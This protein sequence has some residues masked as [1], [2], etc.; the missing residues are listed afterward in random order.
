MVGGCHGVLLLSAKRSVSLV[1]WRTT[2]E[3]RIDENHGETTTSENTRPRT[4]CSVMAQGRR[5]DGHTG[6]CAKPVEKVATASEGEVE[7][8]TAEREIPTVMADFGQSNL[9]L[10]CC[11]VLF[12]VCGCVWLCV[13]L[14]VVVCCCVLLVW[15]LPIRRRTPPPDRPKLAFF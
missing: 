14:C 3:R 12:V 15:T 8:R 6:R 2:H 4:R 13:L 11:C 1:F 10:L 5:G 7:E 9:L